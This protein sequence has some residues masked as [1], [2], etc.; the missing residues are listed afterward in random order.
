MPFNTPD[1]RI[2]RIPTRAPTPS[3]RSQHAI[4]D[5]EP[6]SS[7]KCSNAFTSLRGGK[8][9]PRRIDESGISP[10]RTTSNGMQGA[11]VGVF[12]RTVLCV[13]LGWGGP[14]H[15]RVLCTSLGVWCGGCVSWR[16]WSCRSATMSTLQ[17]PCGNSC[18]PP[19]PPPPPLRQVRSARAPA[20]WSLTLPLHPLFLTAPTFTRSLHK[21]VSWARSALQRRKLP[22]SRPAAQ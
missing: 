8:T 16:S 5:F 9:G 22:S 2:A 3:R 12:A 21:W 13:C 18:S 6:S 14:C 20:P 19:P 11:C 17:R 15:L 7:W 4:I 10:A 1:P